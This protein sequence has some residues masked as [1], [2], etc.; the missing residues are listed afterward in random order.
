MKI[1]VLNLPRTTTRDDLF[2]LFKP[3]GSIQSCTIVMDKQSGTSKGFGFVQMPDQ[4]H[5][6]LAIKNLNGHMIGDKRLRVKVSEAVDKM[7]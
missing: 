3:H 2:K 6:A 1:I 7:A 5:A 4:H